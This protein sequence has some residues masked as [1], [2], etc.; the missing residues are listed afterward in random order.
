MACT[1][2]PEKEN[3]L[4]GWNWGREKRSVSHGGKHHPWPLQSI[5][6]QLLY[7][8]DMVST[9]GVSEFFLESSLKSVLF[10]GNASVLWTFCLGSE[11][12][13]HAF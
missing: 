8:N 1:P 3:N 9:E 5:G 7:L 13:Q 2:F 4:V 10:A 12:L 6:L 11:A